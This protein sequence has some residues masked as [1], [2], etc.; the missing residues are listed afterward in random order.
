MHFSQDLSRLADRSFIDDVA[1][2]IVL[3]DGRAL[4]YTE[5]G[6]PGGKPLFYFHGFPASRFEAELTASAAKKA[7][8]RIIA[9]DRPG[10]GISDGK[11]G[12]TIPGWADDVTEL[13]DALGIGRF[14]ILGVSGGGPY[15]LA[16]AR[17]IPQRL[18]AAGIVCSLGPLS[19]TGLLTEMRWPARLF[20]GLSL[21]SPSLLRLVL[22]LIGPFLRR[23]PSATLNLLTTAAPAAD[24][25]VLARPEVKRILAASM[26]EAFRDGVQGAIAELELY[27]RPWGFAPAEISETVHLWHGTADATVP[28]SHGRY[29][30]A[31]LPHCRAAFVSGEGHFS[32]PLG[33][34]EEILRTLKGRR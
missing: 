13:A 8:L 9:A 23:Q 34:M 11:P 5:Y 29:L 2:K 10:F 14:A 32:L 25:T 20:F 3:G 1:K 30:A 24:R 16:C 18:T 31:A 22:D 6:D 21:R 7:G 4:G 33:H 27:S 19:G 15:A 17:M 26:K 12:R 28:P